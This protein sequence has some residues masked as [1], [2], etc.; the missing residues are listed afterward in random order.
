MK[1][2]AIALAFFLAFLAAPTR[3]NSQTKTQIPPTS[4]HGSWTATAGPTQVLRGT[5]T[6]TVLPHNSNSARGSWSLYLDATQSVI[7]GTWTA[8][9]SAEEWRGSWTARTQQGRTFS[10]TWNSADANLVGKTFED[11]LQRA[12][13]KEIAGNWQSNP[14]SGNWWLRGPAS[15]PKPPNPQPPREPTH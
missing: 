5:W 8:Q 2:A 11:L 4:L 12:M 13:E 6:A 10:G 15:P 3:T 7:Q 14:Y 9:K 1:P